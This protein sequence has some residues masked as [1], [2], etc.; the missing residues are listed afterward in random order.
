MRACC[1]A[2]LRRR[3]DLAGG[4]SAWSASATSATTCARAWSR[5]G[6][7]LL[8]VPTSTRRSEPRA[9][10]A[11]RR[12]GRAGRARCAAECDVLAPCALGGAIDRRDAGRA[13]LRRSS[14]A[15][16]NNVLADEALADALAERG[17]LYAPDFIANAGGLIHVYMRDPRLRRAGR[18]ELVG[19][20]RGRRWTRCSRPPAS[21]GSRRWRRRW[22]WRERRTRR[23]SPA[24]P[25]ERLTRWQPRSGSSAAARSPTRGARRHRR[26]S[27]P[28]A[29]P[30]TIPDLLLLLEHPPVYTKGR[31]ATAGRAADGRGL[32]PDAGDRGLRHRPRRRASPT[33]GPASWSATRSSSLKPYGDDVHDYVRRME[34][35]MIDALG[36]A[37]ASRRG[38]RRSDRG[39]TGVWRRGG[40][41]RK[42]GSIGVHV[43]RGVTTHG[44]AINVN[45]DLQPFE[46]IVPCGIEALPDDVAGARAR[47][48]AG[49]RALRRHGRRAVRRGLRAATASRS[50]PTRW[51]SSS[52]GIEA[53][54]GAPP[55]P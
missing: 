45:N 43:N 37:R 18:A 55:V 15:S 54:V 27:R 42:I 11:R 46:W 16:A 4:A 40:A 31:R 24:S 20:D 29:T 48:R 17:I 3:R 32:V 44:F 5:A 1:R 49:P 22:R 19:R 33:T 6:A 2:P 28:R 36:R 34:R 41:R 47:R 30:A 9:E 14:A 35:V 8:V 26:R 12:V 53:L 25:G 7:E 50:R 38:A 21:G 39:W 10:R 13:A 52:S 23:A 51:P